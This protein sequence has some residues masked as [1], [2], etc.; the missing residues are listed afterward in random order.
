MAVDGRYDRFPATVDH[1]HWLLKAHHQLLEIVA[2]LGRGILEQAG[3]LGQV[4]PRGEAL[5]LCRYQDHPYVVILVDLL[6]DLPKLIKELEAHPVAL[7]RTVQDQM[8]HMILLFEANAF[9]FFHCSSS[10][11]HEITVSVRHSLRTG[12]SY[13]AAS[14][15]QGG[16]PL[17]E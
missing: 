9:V 3:R 8:T 4:Q 1:V 14:R 13:K 10:A 16:R 17:C 7:L 15:N 5:P 2:A 6:E 11:T 12:P